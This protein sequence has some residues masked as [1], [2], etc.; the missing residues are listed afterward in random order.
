MNSK[1]KSAF[2]L[3]VLVQ[4]LHSLEEYLGRLW[5]VFPPARML[6][7][8]VSE[9]LET[10]FLVINIGLFIF[11]LWCWRFPIRKDYF[12]APAVI[13]FWVILETING[14]GHPV[15]SLSQKTYTPG[16][17]TAPFL[18]IIAIYLV[19]LFSNHKLRSTVS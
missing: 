6:T 16:L 18:F 9:N 7:S 13:W 1:I 5:E 15:W 2:F 11:G 3:L 19:R 8:L 12:F 4:G 14:I 10:G 17:A